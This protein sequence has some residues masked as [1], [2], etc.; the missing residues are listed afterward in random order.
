MTYTADNMSRL[1]GNEATNEDVERF[2][3]HLTARGWELVENSDGQVEAYR[4]DEAM[5][6]QE[7]QEE[8]AACFNA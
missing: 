6:E 7:W 5:T 4:D 3:A 2:A 1:L 8:L